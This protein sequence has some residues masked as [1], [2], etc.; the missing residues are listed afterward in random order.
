[1]LGAQ[2]YEGE[3]GDGVYGRTRE[4]RGRRKGGLRWTKRRKDE[5]EEKMEMEG[6]IEIVGI[7]SRVVGNAGLACCGRAYS[8][9]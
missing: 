8:E 5:R 6:N 9:Y 3:G 1:M 4:N 2:F 7:M